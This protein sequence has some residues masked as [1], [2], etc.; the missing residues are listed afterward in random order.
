[1]GA[2][3]TINASNVDVVA[4]VKELTGGGVHYAFEA[5]G[6]KE[7]AEQSFQMLRPAGLATI[8]G[9]VP[10]GT[11]I[12]LHGADFLRDRRIQGTSMGGNNFRVDMPRILAL[13]QQGK[14][15]LDHLIV[16]HIRLD[17]INEGYARMKEGQELRSLISFAA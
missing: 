10:F 8:I 11:R 17:Q 5:V 4:A 2:T 16:G 12:E 6:K 7:T 13:W 3:D 15:K 1:M 14:L 9:M